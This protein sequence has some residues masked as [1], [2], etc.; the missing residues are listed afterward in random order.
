MDFEKNLEIAEELLEKMMKPNI[1]LAESVEFYQEGISKL[2]IA[3][4]N[5][6]DAKMRYEEIKKGNKN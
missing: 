1:T 4:K 2:E 3:Q 5:L 6:E